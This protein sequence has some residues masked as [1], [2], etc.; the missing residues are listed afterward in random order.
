MPRTIIALDK[1]PDR[2]AAVFRGKFSR[3]RADTALEPIADHAGAPADRAF[4]NE[5]AMR[6]FNGVK[7]MLGF[8][9]KAVD[10]VQPAVPRFRDHRQG[11]PIVLG[12]NVL[13]VHEPLNHGI[14]HDPHAVRVRN[15]HGPHQKTGFF[16]PGRAGH[17]AIA[18]LREPTGEDSALHSISSLRQ[19]SGDTSAY[20]SLTHHEFAFAGN[21]RGVTDGY[22]RHI[23]DGVEWA[24][25]PIKRHA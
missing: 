4:F 14:V 18:I 19:D 2:V 15:H 23:G 21:E 22:A 25:C 3:G 7:G 1:H 13:V 5:P 17:F 6:G 10:V 12:I 24:R 16:H 8:H 9:V 11:P 20:R